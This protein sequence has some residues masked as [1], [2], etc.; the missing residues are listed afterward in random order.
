MAIKTTIKATTFSV[1]DTISVHHHFMVDGKKQSQVFTGLVIAIKGRGD[2][3]TFMVRKISSDSIGVEKIW[4]ASSPNITKI[5]IKKKGNPR[6]AKLYYLRN[7]S[8][9][10]ALKIKSR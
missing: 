8:G 10:E 5:T 7:K 6:R 3:K 2:Q 4:P 9:K 1:G